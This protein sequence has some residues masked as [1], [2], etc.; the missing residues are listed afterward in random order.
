MSSRNEKDYY[1]L[2]SVYLDAVFDP[3]FYEDERVFLQEGHHM[4]IVDGRLEHTGV[5][6]NEMRGVFSHRDDV[7]SLEL[8]S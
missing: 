5:V 8:K 7:A 4:R 6:L 1:N 2:V 3:I